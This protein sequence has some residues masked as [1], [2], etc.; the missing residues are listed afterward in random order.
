VT[1]SLT[2]AHLVVFR[3]QLWRKISSRRI[4]CPL[5]GSPKASLVY[6][7]PSVH[8]AFFR[9]I[10]A[11]RVQRCSNC[12][13]VFT[14]PMMPADKLERYY[15]E[16]YL[17]EGLPV[18]RTV[19]EFLSERYKEIWF[20]KQRDLELVLK[21]KNSGRLLDIGCASG[22]LLWL[23]RE[24]GFEVQGVEVGRSSVEFA[25]KVLGI[26]VFLGQ[27]EEAHFA[28]GEFDVVTMIHSLEH[29]PQPRRVLRE[30]HRIL[31][32]N[33]VLVAV[34]PNFV[35]WSSARDGEKWR[36]LQPENHYSHFT[37]VTLANLAAREGFDAE[38][39]TEEGRYGD[40]EIRALYDSRR[41]REIQS[42]LKGSEIVL[43]ARKQEAGR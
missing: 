7:T 5:C 38:V 11:Q 28:A 33:G 26:E 22:T 12:D 34:V 21:S 25:R 15:S 35:S 39:T 29:V 10:F 6:K 13:F 36:W 20:S 27:L 24:K 2:R 18:P 42:E 8:M 9:D 3:H 32:D 1:L 17:L 14:N 31:K 43:M 41:A 40:E 19:E 16:N 37:P 4:P 23:A 30:V